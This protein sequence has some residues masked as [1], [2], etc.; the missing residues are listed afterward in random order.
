MEQGALIFKGQTKKGREIILRYPTIEDTQ[1][2]LDF[3]NMLSKERTFIRFQGEQL[4]FEEE[5][6]YVEDVIKKINEG[7]AIKLLAFFGSD[8]VGVVDITMKD[9]TEKHLG[10]LGITVAKDFRGEGVGKLLMEKVLEEAKK[11][12]TDLEIVTLEAFGNNEMAISMYKKMGF[13]EYGL[14]PDGVK[15]EKGYVDHLYMYK[16]L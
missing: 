12:L 1:K 2:M 6:K 10:V 11:N 4:T 3:I 15:L 9:R 16:K 5:L 13:V 8:L 14:L 7:R